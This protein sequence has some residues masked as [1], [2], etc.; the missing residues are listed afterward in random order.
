MTS[1]Q[2]QNTDKTQSIATSPRGLRLLSVCGFVLTF[3]CSGA[4]HAQ[5]YVNVT[6]GGQFA[7]GVHGQIAIGNNRP[8]PVIYAQPVIAGKPVYGAPVVYMHVSPA[9]YRNWGRHC[10]RYGACGH[11]VH[12]VQTAS[13]NRWWESHNN[14]LRGESNSYRPREYAS[15][16]HESYRNSE[17]R[18]SRRSDDN[19]HRH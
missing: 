11:P 18:E 15:N 1:L 7:P 13:S 3:V 4:V 6:V 17:R 10:A 5:S 2:N 8:P 19:D 9:E 12:F 14:H 16:R